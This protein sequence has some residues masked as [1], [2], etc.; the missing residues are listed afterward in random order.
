MITGRFLGLISGTSADG[1]DAALV[2]ISPDGGVNT[3]AFETFP[4]PQPLRRALIE[5]A[6]SADRASYTQIASLDQRVGQAFADAAL[7]I[8]GRPSEKVVAIGSHGQTLFHSP[9]TQPPFTIQIGDPNRIALATGLPVIGDLRRMDMAAGGQGAPLASALHARV[10]GHAAE[11][12]AV[13]NL[14]GIA[15]LT[16]LP[17][18]ASRVVG[19]DTGPAS[20][21]MDA[22]SM[23]TRKLPFDENGRWAASGEV[24]E[25][26]LERCLDEPYFAQQPPKSTGREYFSAAWLDRMLQGYQAPPEVVQATLCELTAR[27]VGQSL[28]EQ[29]PG[30]AR[31]LV[32]GG[33]IHNSELLRRLRNQLPDRVLES[34]EIHGLDPDAVEAT[35]MAWLAWARLAGVAGNLTSVTGARRP[36]LLGAIYDGRMI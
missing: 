30:C 18:G 16:L 3:V 12:R 22:W 11:D 17:A 5:A 20:C 10:F 15:N 4:Y 32:C 7:A 13:L 35:L 28:L 8:L 2:D 19:F 29:Q 24:D 23:H 34:T 1:I 9:D 6:H 25:K 36:V 14:G 33:G 27:T 21:L 26:L 31:V